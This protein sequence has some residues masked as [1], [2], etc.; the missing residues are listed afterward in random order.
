MSQPTVTTVEPPVRGEPVSL[1]VTPHT[2][3]ANVISYQVTINGGEQQ[4]V[5]AAADGTA[6]VAFVASEDFYDVDVRSV[7]QNDFVSLAASFFFTVDP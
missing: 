3:V 4:T 2:G 1:L 6:T 5:T 7:S